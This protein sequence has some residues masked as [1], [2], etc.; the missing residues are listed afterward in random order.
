M[1][2]LLDLPESSKVVSNTSVC[3]YQIRIA[4]Q[5]PINV[6]YNGV[7][8]EALSR[9]FED[10]LIYTNW[11]TFKDLTASDPGKLIKELKVGLDRRDTFETI[12]T[13]IFTLLKQSEVKAEFAL[14]LI[15]SIDP[16]KIEIPQYIGDGLK[17]LENILC[18][19]G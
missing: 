5:I 16:D 6:S 10:S 15:Y 1:D 4:Y 8:V 11:N 3:D 14:D 19:E 2:E 17:W 12:K 7:D 13:T 9:T 18:T